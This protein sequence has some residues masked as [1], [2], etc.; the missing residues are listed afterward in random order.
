V[1]YFVIWPDGTLFRCYTEMI[2]GRPLG[3]IRSYV[4]PA[5]GYECVQKCAVPCDI[6]RPVKDI[7]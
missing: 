5:D 3:D 1:N 4:P 7:Q 2:E 6:D